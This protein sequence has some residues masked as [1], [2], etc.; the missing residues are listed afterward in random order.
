M[1]DDEKKQKIERETKKYTIRI[2]TADQRFAGTDDRI[3]FQIV[4]S[5]GKTIFMDLN[6][7]MHNDFE[8]GKVD[9]FQMRAA[10]V[11][12]LESVNIQKL[13][14]IVADKWIVARIIIK[15]GPSIWCTPNSL[16]V[17]KDEMVNLPLSRMCP[18]SFENESK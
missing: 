9:D 7:S 12:D 15:C 2:R 1:S 11:G 6:N 16:T 5:V 14:Q 3:M 18:D 17:V 13:H 8:R 4:G 10:C